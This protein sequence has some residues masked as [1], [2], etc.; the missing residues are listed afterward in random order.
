[1]YHY[2]ISEFSRKSNIAVCFLC[3]DNVVNT[4]YTEFNKINIIVYLKKLVVLMFCI[5]YM[6]IHK[7]HAMPWRLS[8]LRV[9]NTMKKICFIN[10]KYSLAQVNDQYNKTYFA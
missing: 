4:V 6:T 10:V 1:M 7:L 8:L 5:K 9:S 2:L 3:R